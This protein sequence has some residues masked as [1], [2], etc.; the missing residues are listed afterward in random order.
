[1]ASR[2]A[3]ETSQGSHRIF[4]K[5][6][7]PYTVY[8]I[9]VL[10]GSCNQSPGSSRSLTAEKVWKH[11]VSGWPLLHG[12]FKTIQKSMVQSP[13]PD[14]ALSLYS[15]FKIKQEV[16]PDRQEYGKGK[17]R[18]FLKGMAMMRKVELVILNSLDMMVI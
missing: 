2:G 12:P 15:P 10:T 7:P 8:K 5:N 11:W 16:C 4:T 17:G 13:T 14:L 3:V 18:S 9:V 1:M 6:L